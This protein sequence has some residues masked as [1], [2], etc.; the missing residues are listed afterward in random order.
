MAKHVNSSKLALASTCA[1]II[2][3]SASLMGRPMQEGLVKQL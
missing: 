3:Y 2:Q 1:I